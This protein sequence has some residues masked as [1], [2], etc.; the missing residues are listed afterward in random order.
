MNWLKI[1]IAVIF[2]VGWV[3]GLTHASSVFEWILTIIAIFLSFYLLI[4]A[5]I[6]LPV[7]TSYAAVVGLGTTGVTLFDF[8]F[9]GQPFNLGK[10]ILII[11]VF[12]GVIN[13]KVVTT[14]AGRRA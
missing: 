6:V 10:I 8:L 14:S 3:I 2:E 9:F 7:G 4:E 13:L 1:V 12:L 11:P 5:S